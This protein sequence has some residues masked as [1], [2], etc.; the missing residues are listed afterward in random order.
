ML[1]RDIN[2]TIFCNILFLFLVNLLKYNFRSSI[3]ESMPKLAVL[4]SMILQNLVV[5][6]IPK[7]IF[8]NR[9]RLF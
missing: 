1:V 7:R 5:P 9:V 2:D 6:S 8:R 4:L 3:N